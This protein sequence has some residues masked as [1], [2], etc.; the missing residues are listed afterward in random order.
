MIIDERY[1]WNGMVSY[2]DGFYRHDFKFLG[3][4][5]GVIE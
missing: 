4:D 2:D 3:Y 5:G 1:V